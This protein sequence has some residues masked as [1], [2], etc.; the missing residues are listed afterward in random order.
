MYKF[1][2][3]NEDTKK[4]MNLLLK[5]E[6][7]DKMEC[8][9]CELTTFVNFT[10]DCKLNK[11][12]F[13]EEVK[14]NYC[15]WGEIRSQVFSLVKGKRKPKVFKIILSLSEEGTERLHHNAKACFLNI[16]FENDM[17]VFTTGTAQKEFDLSKAVDEAWD[18][19]MRVFFKRLGVTAIEE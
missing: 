14:R 1:H 19:V 18:N 4:F 7:F 15:L 8:R 9:L 5:E 17:V 2:I 11:D 16:S 6:S 13:D 12:F 3:E 10:I